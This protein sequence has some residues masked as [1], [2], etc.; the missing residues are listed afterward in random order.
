MRYLWLAR[1]E[2]PFI[3]SL[4][5][6]SVLWIKDVSSHPYIY[7]FSQPKL[8][9]HVLCTRRCQVPGMEEWA[10]GV[11]GPAEPQ[12]S[13][14]ADINHTPARR[15]GGGLQEQPPVL[16]PWGWSRSNLVMTASESRMGCWRELSFWVVALDQKPSFWTYWTEDQTTHRG[17]FTLGRPPRKPP[18]DEQSPPQRHVSDATYRPF[19]RNFFLGFL[20]FLHLHFSYLFTAPRPQVF[21]QISLSWPT[22]SSFG[23][24]V[25]Y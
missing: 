1:R 22:L 19:R 13:A 3:R 5:W 20:S 15:L 2:T 17:K 11:P 6:C 8:I 25:C 10:S 4:V 7:P 23:Q 12:A 21:P 24:T 16:A 14:D 18:G 9:E